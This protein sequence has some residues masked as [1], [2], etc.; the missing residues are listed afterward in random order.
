MRE[1][2]QIKPI[3]I[4]ELINEFF[5]ERK[6][7]GKSLESRIMDEWESLIPEKAIKHTKPITI[8]SKVLLIAVSNS[9]W[10]HQLTL[11]KIE[12]LKTIQEK[13]NT[14]DI[15]DIRFKIGK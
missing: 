2:K 8:K 4:K 10:L 13:L 12:L 15:I 3:V 5:K 14:Q 11:K 1:K 7:A 6:S 9:A